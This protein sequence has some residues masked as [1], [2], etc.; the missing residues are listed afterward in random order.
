MTEYERGW[1][2]GWE[3]VLRSRGIDPTSVVIPSPPAVSRSHA[4][5][6]AVCRDCGSLCSDRATRCFDCF[7]AWQVETGNPPTAI[8]RERMTAAALSRYAHVAERRVKV[9]AMSAA[10]LSIPEIAEAL[11]AR[12]VRV[13]LDLK[14]SD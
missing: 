1:R 5:R 12:P 13:R 9:R 11:G 3:A 4:Y 10:G 7:Q 14:R 8:A 2:D 6:P